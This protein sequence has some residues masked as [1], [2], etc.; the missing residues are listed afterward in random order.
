MTRTPKDRR[1]QAGPDPV[2]P[3]QPRLSGSPGF[4]DPQSDRN[5]ES[6][7]AG[8]SEHPGSRLLPA[9]ASVRVEAAI[10]P[11]PAFTATGVGPGLPN[12]LPAR[13]APTR[14][15]SPGS[16]HGR[17]LNILK[18]AVWNI[19]SVPTMS[20][21]CD[22]DVSGVEML[23]DELSISMTRKGPSKWQTLS[24]SRARLGLWRPGNREAGNSDQCSYW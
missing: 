2:R 7:Q 12:T 22:N 10:D 14:S 3:T 16:R 19:V 9:C 5:P 4:K 23:L 24:N 21:L 8:K 13:K 18:L 15:A 11:G 17:Y 20:A 1:H 6:S